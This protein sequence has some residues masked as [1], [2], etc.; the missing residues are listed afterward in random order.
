MKVWIDQ[1]QCVGN[2]VCAE[3]AAAVFALDVND[4]AFV[5]ENGRM[6]RGDEMATVPAG[7]EQAVLDAAD[8]CPAACIYV[9]A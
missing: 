2:G 8:E 6:L 7:L 9:D 4:V 1:R 3:L 5:C